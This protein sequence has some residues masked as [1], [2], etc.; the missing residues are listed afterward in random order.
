[1]ADTTAAAAQAEKVMKKI[2]NWMGKISNETLGGVIAYF[3]VERGDRK[4]LDVQK[5]RREAPYFIQD[6][7][8]EAQFNTLVV[9]LD[10]V[11]LEKNLAVQMGPLPDPM[12]TGTDPFTV[13]GLGDNQRSDVIL[14]LVQILTLE[15]IPEA[16][17]RASAIHVIRQLAEISNPV[18]WKRRAA[19]FRLM[20]PRELDYMG[21]SI[22][23][24]LKAAWRGLVQE[25]LDVKTAMDAEAVL[26]ND[27][28]DHIL[29]DLDV[30]NNRT[31]IFP[32]GLKRVWY[33]FTRA[34]GFH[35]S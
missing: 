31:W 9:E 14:T 10:D 28:T 15:S 13:A 22:T 6:L 4:V 17:R 35:F 18:D 1:M 12:P 34:F 24:Q 11:G 7:Q 19:A 32:S 23:N 20:K 16:Q 30:R 29:N 26:L 27:R 33:G 2:L 8:D 25:Y 3:L 21:A 5:L